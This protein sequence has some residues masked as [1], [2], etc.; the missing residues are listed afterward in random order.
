MIVSLWT[1][2][3]T[4]ATDDRKSKHCERV[5]WRFEVDLYFRGTIRVRHGSTI[6]QSRP[7]TRHGWR[8]D[9]AWHAMPGR[10]VCNRHM[11]PSDYLIDKR[12]SPP[13]AVLDHVLAAVRGK[14]HYDGEVRRGD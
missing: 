8:N 6:Y 5:E 14:V 11:I 13:S 1:Y 2:G 3:T 7:S 10:D 12:P 9:H 4:I